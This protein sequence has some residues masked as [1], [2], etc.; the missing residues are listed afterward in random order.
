MR[1]R[2]SIERPASDPYAGKPVTTET[3]IRAEK[4]RMSFIVIVVGI[5]FSSQRNEAFILALKSIYLD[6]ESL[7]SLQGRLQIL[8][9]AL[10]LHRLST[11][12]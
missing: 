3:K 1:S 11:D 8:R 2:S 12:Q 10:R 6:L 5:V 7:D 4:P 9:R